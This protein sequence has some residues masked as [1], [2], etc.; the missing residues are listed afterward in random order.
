MECRVDCIYAQKGSRPIVYIKINNIWVKA[1]ID[2]GATDVVWCSDSIDL[3]NQCNLKYVAESD[4]A[5]YGI[6]G[7]TVGYSL[8]LGEISIGDFHWNR[9]AVKVKLD[10]I[11]N[12]KFD[13]ILG[14]AMFAELNVKIFSKY[15]FIKLESTSNQVEQKMFIGSEKGSGYEFIQFLE[16]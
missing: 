15:G 5:I 9:V 13:I 8:Y 4:D 1:L 2:T 16:E 3:W 6:N 12:G 11:Q 7:K 10:S 14:M